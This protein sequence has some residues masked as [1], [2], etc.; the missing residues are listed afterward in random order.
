MS[1]INELIDCLTTNEQYYEY[2]YYEN[3]LTNNKSESYKDGN[4]ID[5]WVDILIVST[6]KRKYYG[7]GRTK[8]PGNDTRTTIPNIMFFIIWY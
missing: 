4:Q 6:G 5:Q 2:I 7:E 8:L 3:Q 1:V